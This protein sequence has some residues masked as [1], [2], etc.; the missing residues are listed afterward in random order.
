MLWHWIKTTV[1]D[2]PD[3]MIYLGYGTDDFYRQGSQ[4]LAE[5][6]PPDRVYAIP[7]G[8]DYPTFKALWKV[9]LSGCAP[10]KD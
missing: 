1:G 7:G 10:L 4:L 5:V 3:K 9:F 2:H 6:L 8:H